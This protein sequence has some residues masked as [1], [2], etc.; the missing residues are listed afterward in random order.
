MICYRNVS[1]P[2]YFEHLYMFVLLS[3]IAQGIHPSVHHVAVHLSVWAGSW[4]FWSG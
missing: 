3:V 1:K 4:Y 2:I